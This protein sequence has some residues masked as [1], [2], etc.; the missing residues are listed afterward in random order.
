M[1]AQMSAA[2]A[3][4]RRAR[5]GRGRGWGRSAIAPRNGAR[6]PTNSTSSAIGKPRRTSPLSTLG[7]YWRNSAVLHSTSPATQNARPRLV[8]RQNQARPPRRHQRA[9]AVQQ[10]RGARGHHQQGVDEP[11][12]AAERDERVVRGRERR[13]GRRHHEVRAA[14]QRHSLALPARGIRHPGLHHLSATAPPRPPRRAPHR[15]GGRPRRAP[16]QRDW[17]TSAQPATAISGLLSS[18][19]TPDANARCA[20]RAA[21]AAGPSPS[22]PG[23]RPSAG[24]RAGARPGGAT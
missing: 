15:A 13:A 8:S 23:C 2:S 16:R 21:R 20:V 1:A 4:A 14:A 17:T 10:Q 19:A 5:A 12:G 11:P 22:S 7:S 24:P 18:C 6:K 3:R 9:P